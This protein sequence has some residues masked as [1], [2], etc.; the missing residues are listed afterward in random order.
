MTGVVTL[1]GVPWDEQSSF[2][3]GAAEAPAA[4]R[5]ALVSPSSNMATEEGH[6]LSLGKNLI[7]AGDITLPAD[8]P[9]ARRN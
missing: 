9:A 4:I 7:D 3:R 5:Q 1:L 6:E 8:D 2:M